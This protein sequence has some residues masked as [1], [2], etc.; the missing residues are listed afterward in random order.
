MYNQKI[1]KIVLV[2]GLF[3]SF[4]FIAI[5]QTITEEEVTVI[6]PYSPTI[7]KA[8]KINNFPTSEENTNTKFKLEY[9][10]NPKLI[11]TIFELEDLKAARYISP[12]EPK[13]KQNVVIAGMGLY[14]TPYAELF[15]NGKLNRNFTLGLHIKH[16]SSKASVED[17]GYSGFSK[18]G[19]EVWTK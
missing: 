6:A 15:L 16:L 9:Y 7:S 13:Y 11:S 10:T 8:Q 19:A 2:I 18:S 17:Y 1:F 4:E 5:A 14:T 3:L 12:K